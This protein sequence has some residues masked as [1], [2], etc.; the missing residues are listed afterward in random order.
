MQLKGLV[1][2]TEAWKKAKSFESAFISFLKKEDPAFIVEKA[3]KL[4]HYPFV[5]EDIFEKFTRMKTFLN[6]SFLKW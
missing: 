2:K 3:D 1:K 6:N 5:I 4:E